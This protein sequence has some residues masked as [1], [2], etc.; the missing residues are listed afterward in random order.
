MSRPCEGKLRGGY[1]KGQE[2]RKRLFHAATTDGIDC[3]QREVVFCERH[4]EAFEDALLMTLIRLL[5]GGGDCNR[6]GKRVETLADIYE[7]I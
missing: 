6:C 3:R 2:S 4:W 7:A 1:C 5:A